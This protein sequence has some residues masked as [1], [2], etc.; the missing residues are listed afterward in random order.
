MN[1]FSNVRRGRA[2]TPVAAAAQAVLVTLLSPSLAA[3]QSDATSTQAGSSSQAAAAVASTQTIVVTGA[4]PTRLDA[5]ATATSRLGA[6]VRETPATVTT[7]E[8]ADIEATGALDTQAVLATI[9]GVT[10]SAQ[11]GAPGSVFYRGFGSSSLAQLY[12]GISVQYDAIAARPVDSWIVERVEAIGGPSSFLNGSGAVGGTINIVTKL[13]DLQGDLAQVRAGLGDVNQLALGV[14]RGFGERTAPDHV[15]RLEL[16]RTH[17]GGNDLWTTARKRDA[18][19]AAASWRAAL[20]DVFGGA[21]AH[22]LAVER[23]HEKLTQPYWGT[24]ILRNAA[25]AVTGEV[26]FDPGTLGVNYNAVD[27][28]Y[29]QDVTW[30]RSILK[31][32]VSAATQATHTFY[33]YDALRDY[34]NIET[35]T[36]VNA[37]TQVQRSG[38]LLQRHDQQVYGSR[39]EAT[40]RTAF[41]AM[42]SDFAFGWD[43]AFNRQTRFP[44]SVAGPFDTTDPYQPADTSFYATPGVTQTYTP[45]ATN[46]LHMAAL[47]AENRTVLAPGWAVTSG[48]RADVISLSRHWHRAVSATNPEYYER[49]Y[50]PVTGRLG[51]VHDLSADWQVYALY[52]TAADP[53]SGVLSTA[54]LSALRDFDLTR[55]RQFEIGTKASFDAR[56]GE[57]A[58]SLFDIVRENLSTTDPNDRTRV[59]PVGQQSSR[60]VELSARW[61]PAAAWQLALQLAAI[62]AQ[63]DEFN[64]VVGT[65]TVSRAGN[66]PTNVPAVVA[67]A[68]AAWTPMA[69]W[70]L[71]GEWRHVGRRFADTAN[72]VWDG[73]YHLLNLG[74]RWQVAPPWAVSVRVYN[75]TD[76]TYAASVGS[77]LAVLGAPRSVQAVVDW[78][79]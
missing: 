63:Y 11:P 39:A 52:S 55:G 58:L 33:F 46:R 19:Q 51:A 59:V 50:R 57:L 78:R 79:Y 73:A 26:Q 38:A 49:R 5:P 37:N 72:T 7:I 21:L 77:N 30:A 71:S 74:A 2:L 60:G 44:L 29:Q 70:T 31:W 76:R 4:A 8:R 36:F 66:R 56:R 75:V 43:Y 42:R 25:G 47:F 68:Q 65:Q 28:R 32:N 20:G 16:N 10:F 54:G 13:A 64:E 45:D 18:W 23:Q 48:L 41:G 34:E 62:D 61:R 12:N 27:G 15:L 9:P 22:T 67:G 17:A 40:H 6:S 14:Q 69:G 53:P 1:P 35:Y 24:P 3:A